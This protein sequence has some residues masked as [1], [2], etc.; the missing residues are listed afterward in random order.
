MELFREILKFAT[1]GV[2]IEVIFTAT[3]QIIEA[4]RAGQKIN[5]NLK[6]FSYIWMLPIYGSIALFA[7]YFMPLVQDLN[8]LL[9][10]L[11]YGIVILIVEYI[12]G[13]ILKALTGRCPWHYESKWALHGF[14]RFDYLPLW[15]A[16]GLLVEWY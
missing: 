7:R 16:F 5:L 8:I 4:K 15:M 6:G 9:R 12:C 2:T 1:F 10:A 11:I 3:C 14:I 13:F